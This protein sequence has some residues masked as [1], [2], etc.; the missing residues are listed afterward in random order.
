[1]LFSII[2]GTV[3]FVIVISSLVFIHEYGHF[4]GCKICGVKVDSFSIGMGKEIY[5]FNDKNG[6]RW[7]FCLFPIG[8]YVKMFGDDDISSGKA[9]KK[10]LE[11]LSE[12][13][14]KKTFYFQNVYRKFLIVFMG[15]FFNL[16][17]ATFILTIFIRINGIPITK[18]IIEKI[19][20]NSP[21]EKYELKENDII[22]SINNKEIKNFDEITNIIIINNLDKLNIKIKRN[23]EIIEKE[24]L[25]ELKETKDSFGNKVKVPFLG[26]GAT[27][28]EYK[29]VNIFISFW[30]AI[31]NV[32]K[33]CRDTLIVLIQIIIRKRNL[34]GLGGPLKIAKYSFQSF[35]IGISNLIYFTALISTNLGFMN[36]LPIPVLDGGYLFFFSIEIIFRKKIPEK[37]QTMLLNCGFYLLLLIMFFSTFNDLK[38]LF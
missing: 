21:A 4:L 19:I 30:T 25:P 14:K 36:L 11:N 27:T 18:P 1:M 10:I 35:K 26:I 8:G 3:V 20:Q 15:P 28:K 31:K 16:L 37:I 7:K 29:K 38:S 12:E 5:G 34:D 24:I 33:M 9:D 13:E 2:Q 32:Y 22:L 6:V 17:L 23:N